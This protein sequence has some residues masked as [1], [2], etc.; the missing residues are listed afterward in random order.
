MFFR[1]PVIR[2]S[3]QITLHS[4]LSRCLHRWLPINPVPPVIRAFNELLF[5]KQGFSSPLLLPVG[6]NG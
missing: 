1:V 3:I 6:A 2:L 5:L 4:F